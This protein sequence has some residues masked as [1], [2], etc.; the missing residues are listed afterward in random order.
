[1]AVDTEIQG[2]PGSIE[3]AGDWLS[4]TLRTGVDHTADVVAGARRSAGASWH[5]PAGEQF[6]SRAG[7]AVRT[8]DDLSSSARDV[9]TALSTFAARLRSAQDRMSSIRDTAAGAGLAV[10]GFVISDPG[11]GPANPG[12]LPATG[13][14]SP[15]AEQAHD[16]AVAAFD[17]HQE[18]IRAY[19]AAAR[20][21]GDVQDDLRAGSDALSDTYRGLQGANWLTNGGDL[22][23]GLGG[24]V[25]EFQAS[26]LRGTADTLGRTAREFMETARDA[27]PA[28]V[29]RERWY[30]DLDKAGDDVRRFDDLARHADDLEK[31][32]KRL[33]LKLGGALTVVGIGYD[34]ATGKDPVE[35]TASGLGGVGAPR[36]PGAG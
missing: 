25:A 28:I 2:S 7:G 33:P 6:A 35:A 5:G 19:N 12:A 18:K 29:G 17:D 27:D 22:M 13:V 1:M 23:G 9:A 4:G 15:A 31:T 34:I 32:A 16:R 14:P 36:G 8:I 24:A 21:A 3:A 10:S 26:T 30:S 20:A 11:P